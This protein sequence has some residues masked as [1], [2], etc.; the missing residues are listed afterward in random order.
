MRSQNP[1]DEREEGLEVLVDA[2]RLAIAVADQHLVERAVLAAV[3]RLL[4]D[5][6]GHLLLQLRVGDALAVVAHALDEDARSGH[7]F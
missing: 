3:H 6:R 1:P 2:M 7:R 4:A 5:E